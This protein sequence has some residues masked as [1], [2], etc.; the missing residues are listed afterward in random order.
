[1][2]LT[3]L[4]GSTGKETV[5]ALRDAHMS[6]GNTRGSAHDP[7]D[8]I[9][10]HARWA[11][12]TA[13]QLRHRVHPDDVQ[14]LIFTPGFTRLLTL[15]AGATSQPTVNALVDLEIDDRLAVLD[16][17]CSSMQARVDRHRGVLVVLDTNVYVEH[18]QKLE[19]LDLAPIIDCRDEP[20]H[21]LVPMVVVD[22]L[23]GLKRSN[24]KEIRWRAPYTLAFLSE[25]LRGTD[26]I[27]ELR[28]ADTSAL[29]TGGIP[30]GPITAEI[31]LDPPGHRRL[32]IN[33]DEIVDR[34]VAIKL[35]VG[36]PVT[37]VTFDTGMAMRAR[38]AN[39]KVKRLRE[40]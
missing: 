30:R 10:A 29:A 25:H 32:P 3:P 16:A 4:P 7:V 34:A 33:D 21:L 17:A 37:L 36:R 24:R 20:L 38:A 9:A 8:R 14:R 40:E 28:P 2:Q 18:E 35:T 5:A 26:L 13:R 19:D 1:M 31:V 6:L 39:L 12:E 23:D 11:S 27:G 15:L 22:E